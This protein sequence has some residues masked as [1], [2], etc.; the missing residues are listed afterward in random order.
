MISVLS[1]ISTNIIFLPLNRNWIDLQPNS[2]W[3]KKATKI[4]KIVS[5]KGPRGLA[6]PALTWSYPTNKWPSKCVANSYE[7]FSSRML[8]CRKLLCLNIQPE[9]RWKHRFILRLRL[10]STFIPFVK[11]TE[12]SISILI[13]KFDF[14]YQKVSI[15][16]Q[17]MILRIN[18]KL[19]C[20]RRE[21][22]KKYAEQ[23]AA[24]VACKAL[25]LIDDKTI[26]DCLAVWWNEN[27]WKK[28]GKMVLSFVKFCFYL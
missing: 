6:L 8:I 10:K 25:R 17:I 19:I 26:K 28:L 23:G 12:K 2:L 11:W 1:G 18:F 20:F 7:K 9:G 24:M 21:K 5:F 15:G 13:C 3:R 22:N 16:F 4:T 14:V 27:N